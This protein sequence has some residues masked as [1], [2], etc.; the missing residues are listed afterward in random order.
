MK[1][2]V[3]SGIG[4][5][6]GKTTVALTLAL[7]L[8]A[9]YWKPIECGQEKDS[10]QARHLTDDKVHVHPPAYSFSHPMSPNLAA[11]KDSVSVNF[12]SIVPPKSHCLII[13]GAGG[14]LVP[15]TEN[16]LMIDLFQPLE[17]IHLLVTTPYLGAINHTL[18]TLEALRHRQIHPLGLVVNGDMS[19]EV[20]STL[21]TF[22]KIPIFHRLPW[23][24][25]LDSSS[26][27]KLST[28]WS[29]CKQLNAL[30]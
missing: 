18:L 8:K 4:T 16:K 17:A 3:I 5:D 7:Y 10:I 27:H 23:I 1:R 22:G 25:K 13:E 26:F 9:D 12:E 21:Q 24:E 30:F 6:V 28:T 29:T 14:V 15:L 11:R 19:K 2:I 20:E